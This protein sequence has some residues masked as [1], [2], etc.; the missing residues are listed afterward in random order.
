[1][2][3]KLHTSDTNVL[4]NIQTLWLLVGMKPRSLSSKYTGSTILP[5]ERT[6]LAVRMQQAVIIAGA[7]Y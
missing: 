6:P 2:M 7:S 5:E 4:M 3:E 1:M